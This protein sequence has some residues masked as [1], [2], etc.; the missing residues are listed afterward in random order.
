MCSSISE[1]LA[2]TE[3]AKIP[4]ANRKGSIGRPPVNMSPKTRSQS[5][6]RRLL[7]GL[8][9]CG[10]TSVAVADIIT[11]G[12]A[13]TQSTQDGTGP[14]VNN[15]GLNNIL[16]GD[17]YTVTLAFAGSITAPGIYNLTG[18]S[19]TFNVPAPP[20]IETSFGLISLTV[21]ANAGFDEFSLFACLITGSDCGSSNQLNSNFKVLTTDLNSPVTV[22][23]FGLDQPHPLD[24]LE[25]DGTTDIQGSIRSYSYSGAVSA[26]PEPSPRIVLCCVLFAALG[27]KALQRIIRS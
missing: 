16:T 12:G 21:N 11:F 20:A 6:W 19:L 1:V 10:F 9:I 7:A 15:P 18:A 2:D 24:L 26:V 4:I 23:A 27:W 3:V 13:I 25:D 17:G 5:V 14:A 8:V 22:T